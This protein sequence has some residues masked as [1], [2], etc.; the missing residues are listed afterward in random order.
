[1]QTLRILGYDVF[2]GGMSG[3]LA[4]CAELVRARRENPGARPPALVLALNPE[5]VV[6]ARHD[7]ELAAALRSAELLIPDGIG[8]C[9]AA[10]SLRGRWLGRVAGADLMPQLCALAVEHD[11][12][13]FLYGAR[14]E[15]NA[16]AARALQSRFPGLRIVGRAHGYS[17][18]GDAEAVAE[19]I[20]A[21][22]PDI[23]F[24]ALGSPRQERWMLAEC[25]RLPVAVVQGVGGTFDVLAGAAERAPRAM[26]S[27]GLEWL[28]RLLD[29]PRRWRRQLAL[30]SFARWV[31]IGAFVGRL[32][33]LP[34]PRR[35]SHTTTARPTRVAAVDPITPTKPLEQRLGGDR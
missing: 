32:P 7:P 2:A 29:D 14:P 15:V 16:S 25:A 19:Q 33:K 9:A 28:Y 24:V 27:M 22:R 26:R 35:A 21:T 18:D 20:R 3:A 34:R 4:C 23:V 11:F 1:M 6:R 5:K 8:V 17:P 30:V 31:A 12:G 10:L 13:V